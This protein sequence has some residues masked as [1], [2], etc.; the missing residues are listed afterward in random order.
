M[1]ASEDGSRRPERVCIVGG[2]SSGTHLAWLLK[3]RGWDPTIFE[4][5]DRLGGEIWTR[6]RMPSDGG[7]DNVTRELGAAFLSPDY[8]EVRALLARYNQTEQPISSVDEMSFHVHYPAD[9]P[10]P[11]QP[12]PASSSSSSPLAEHV[13]SP[14]S[15][16]DHWVAKITG[17]DDAAANN[18]AVG[19]ALDAYYVLHESIFGPMGRNRF[20]SEPATDEQLEAIR[21]SGVAFLVRNGLDI[22]QP[23][24]YQ[25]FVLQGMGRLDTMPAYYML[26]WCNPATLQQGGFG[27]TSHPLAMLPQ[28]YGS[29]VDALAAEADIDVR[30]N[31]TVTAVDRSALEAAAAGGGGGGQIRLTVR[32]SPTG[33]EEVETCDLLALSGPITDFVRGSNDGSRPAIL[34]PPTDEEVSLFGPKQPMQFLIQLLDLEPGSPVQEN[35]EALEFWPVNF[36]TTGGVIV[37][38]DISYAEENGGN[39]PPNGT[40]QW[41]H[42]IGG[43]QSYSYWPAPR[44][45]EDRHLKAQQLWLDQHNLTVKETLARVFFDTYLFHYGNDDVMARKPWRLAPLQ[46]PFADSPP[47]PDSSATWSTQTVYVGGTAGYETVEDSLQFNLELVHDLFDSRDDG[48]DHDGAS[49]SASAV[50]SATIT[51]T[52]A[53]AAAT[54]TTTASKT[55][56]TSS[57]PSEASLAPRLEQLQFAIPCDRVEAFVAADDRTWTAFLARQAAFVRKTVLIDGNYSSPSFPSSPPSSSS[58]SA[59][60]TANCSVW[61]AVQWASLELWKRIPAQDLEDVQAAFV[62]AF[63]PDAPVPV[64]FPPTTTDGLEVMLDVPLPLDAPFPARERLSL[65]A[66]AAAAAAAA[67]SKNH[68][69]KLDPAV[70]VIRF[71]LTQG[72]GAA[73]VAAFVAADNATWT[74]Y[75]HTCPGFVRKTTLFEEAAS[76]DPSDPSDSSAC[77]MWTRARWAS[78]EQWA[79]CD[80]DGDAIAATAAA[81]EAQLGYAPPMERWPS[82]ASLGV[83]RERELPRGPRLV[84]VGGNDVVAYQSLASGVDF[85]VRGSPSIARLL[86][87]A[88]LF[89]KAPSGRGAALAALHPEPYEFWFASEENAAAF[90]LDPMRYVPAFGGHCT[91]GIANLVDGDLEPS[92]MADGRLAFVCVNTTSWGK[93]VNGTLYMNSCG[94]YDDFMKD[95]EGDI[96]KASAIWEG[97]FGAPF[98]DTGPVN[99]ACFQDGATWGGP[100]N[101]TAGLLPPSCNIV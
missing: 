97:W 67:A 5:N 30:L 70:E 43:L 4:R 42:T 14:Q 45:D 87:S 95:P 21:G 10:D 13:V 66:A 47:A 54:T 65:E 101:W 83:L 34:T 73:D 51:T 31:A 58:A 7:G 28:G 71:E 77:Y 89:A 99:D 79:A 44:S 86:P 55:T 25:F 81:F 46:Q 48:A 49:A 12:P 37:R 64:A 29:I 94:M 63:G 32:Y 35:F 23:L 96:A 38:R 6:H 15:W 61:S 53:A 27:D 62:E 41:P 3:R 40:T 17:S 11:F 100:P 20:P 59:A 16:A 75:L 26:K 56:T 74:A 93:V 8:D 88:A 36:Q 98:T 80:A 1:C 76:S 57:W 39:G 90:D 72:C 52:A 82:A 2:G 22:L 33:D 92:Q 78:R 60:S 84:A 68:S 19:E 50:A 85:D 9:Q 91:H 69:A 18:A 24:L